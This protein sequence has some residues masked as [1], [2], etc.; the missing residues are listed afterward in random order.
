MRKFLFPILLTVLTM[1]AC[2]GQQTETTVTAEAIIDDSVENSDS[3]IYGLVCDG[4]NDTLLVV[5]T[6]ISADPDTF[7]IL[8]VSR[9]HNVY[10]RLLIGDRVAVVLTENGAQE[11]ESRDRRVERVVDI[12]Q[13]K[14]MWAYLVT[15]TLRQRADVSKK[16]EK[17]FLERVPASLLQRLLQPR[18]YG[19]ELK[20]DGAARPIGMVHR[21][22]T[23]D[24]QSPVVY[25][26]LK[27]Y[28]EWALS[29]GRL[30]L[31]ETRM[32]SLGQRQV[33]N[34]DTADLVLLMRDSLV[35]R[36]ADGEQ[37]Y[38]RKTEKK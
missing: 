29:N 16:M 23:S 9:R 14:A 35:L 18:E 38:Y 25:P 6:D 21:G 32:D 36:F 24:Q 33:I 26:E 10:G 20:N 37:S 31:S 19:F 1:V 5:L 2:G 12:D 13:L 7:N 11:T 4:T 17:E 3:A 8:D 27:R 28:R 22:N 34:S 15:P 30:V